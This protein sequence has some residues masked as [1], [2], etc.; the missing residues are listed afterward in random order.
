M[1]ETVTGTPAEVVVFP[2]ASL[3]RA[4][5]V[6]GPF[7][8]LQ[9]FQVTEYGA[10]VS[11]APSGAPSTRNYTPAT[12]SLSP[13]DAATLTVVPDTVAPEEG[14]VTDTVG[15]VVSQSDVVALIVARGDSLSEKS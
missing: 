14:A 15:G 11:S 8:W 7:T 10:L 5:T 1:F 13:A 9:V 3:A 12:A 4:V 6:C 2:E